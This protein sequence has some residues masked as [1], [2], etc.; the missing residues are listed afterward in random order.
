ML[1]LPLIV[2]FS[3]PPTH[4]C[5]CA[6]VLMTP[7]PK[8]SQIYPLHFIST[9]ITL[10]QSTIFSSLRLLQWALNCVPASMLILPQSIYHTIASDLLKTQIKSCLL[11]A[12]VTLYC[13][14]SKIQFSTVVHMT[15][16]KLSPPTSTAPLSPFPVVQFHTLFF[17]RHD[18]LI[19]NPC[20]CCILPL[21]MLFS[22]S[23]HCGPFS[24]SDLS[25]LR[26]SSP[27]CPGES[28]DFDSIAHILTPALLPF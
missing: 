26:S 10:V 22:I 6:H 23:M 2:P 15:K 28:R 7:H 13:V 14:W 18:M 12:P 27:T 3:S 24:H 4:V 16:H 9:T 8:Q 17:L 21:R 20:T 19:H 25:F 1:A 5:S 11:P